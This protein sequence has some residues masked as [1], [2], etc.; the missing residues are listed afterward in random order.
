MSRKRRIKERRA[1]A[2]TKT[3]E[4]KYQVGFNVVTVSVQA[5]N[6]S[7]ARRYIKNQHPN[8]QIIDVYEI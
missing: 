5:K 4:V 8:A 7:D 2:S 6:P 3:Y 1:S